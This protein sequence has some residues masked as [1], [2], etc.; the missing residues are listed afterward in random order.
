MR[1]NY[2]RKSILILLILVIGIVCVFSLNYYVNPYGFFNSPQRAEFIGC[3]RKAKFKKVKSLTK[4][5]PEAFVLGSS[6]SMRL[7]P[8]EIKARTGLEAFNF[9]VFY[10]TAEDQFVIPQALFDLEHIKPKLFIFCLDAFGYRK[11]IESVDVVFDGAVNRLSYFEDF[12]KYLPDYSSTKLN[13]F[14]FKSALTL[15]QTLD[16]YTALKNGNLKEVTLD[17]QFV[18]SFKKGGIR[19][20]YSNWESVEITDKAENGEYDIETYIKQKDIQFKKARNG[21]KGIVSVMGDYDFE[22]LSKDRLQLLDSVIHFLEERDC[23]VVLNIMPVQPYFYSLLKERTQHQQNIQDLYDAC[24]LMEK[25]YSN[26][27]RLKDNSKIENFNGVS[28]HFFDSYHPTSVNST[29]MIES[30]KLNSLLT[31]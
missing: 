19:K 23:K 8:K 21:Y 1:K 31:K 17:D 26:V 9:G 2:K 30:F 14:R 10:A 27:I 22:G 7:L 3:A 13:W 28:N 20:H 18:K 25:K 12:S 15:K 4:N 6:N 29:L 16:S 5:P 11:R 24:L